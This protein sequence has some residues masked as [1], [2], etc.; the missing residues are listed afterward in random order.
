M[1]SIL[2][3]IV[4][5]LC[6]C[7]AGA[8]TIKGKVYRGVGDTVV[9]D[10]IVYYGGSTIGTVVDAQGNFE[11]QAKAQAIP[12]TVSCVGYYSATVNY[13]QNK[14]LIVRLNPKNEMLRTVT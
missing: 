5:L 8:Q 1:K 14:P 2:L 10:A 13:E 7:A 9:A 6:V 4:L 11:I 12:I 3:W